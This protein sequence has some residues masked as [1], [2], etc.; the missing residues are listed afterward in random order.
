MIFVNIELEL[1]EITILLM[2]R[3]MYVKMI[4]TIGIE[5]S[6]MDVQVTDIMLSSSNK[7]HWSQFILC[8]GNFV[9][10]AVK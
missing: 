4:N 2:E 6:L 8:I 10:V 3:R 5:R 7:K 1:M 9:I